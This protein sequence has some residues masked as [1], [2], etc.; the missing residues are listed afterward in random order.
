[1]QST[2]F[3]FIRPYSSELASLG[4]L[5]EA[6]SNS[7]PASA[8]VKLRS[9]AEQS[10]AQIYQQ[11]RL[12]R[13]L[14]TNLYDLITYDPFTSVIPSE[15]LSKFHSL[16][17]QGNKA[18]H[19]DKGSTETAK[20]I[21]REAHALACWMY[22]TLYN[23]DSTNCPAFKDPVSSADA[24]KESD[25]KRRDTLR[26]L[27]A[28]EAQMQQLLA[29]LEKTQTKAEVAEKSLEELQSLL[30]KGRSVA[31]AL[32]FDEA[33]TRRQM[34]DVELIDAGWN[35]G[36]NRVSTDEVGQ[37]IALKTDNK[38]EYADYVLYGEDG[39]PLAVVEAKRTMISPESGRKQAELY[40]NALELKH[41]QRPIIFYT[42]GFE[43]YLWN[44]GIKDTPRMIYGFYS[45]DSLEYLIFQ[46]NNRKKLNEVAPDSEIAGRMYQIEAVKR[47]AERF[48]NGH[49]KALIVQATGTG[50]TRVAISLCDLLSRALWAKRILFLCDRREL[51]KQANNVF[52]EYLPGEPRIYVTA[53]TA[54]DRDQRIYLATYPAM[55]NCFQSFDVGFFD[56]IIADESHRSIYNRYGDL[57]RYF[58]ALQVGLTATPVKF[59][60]KNTYELFGCRDQD[61][62]FYYSYEEA[63]NHVP[64]YLVP[65]EVFKNTTEFMRRGIKYS[66]MKPE[67]RRQLEEDET[68]PTLIDYEAA[69]IDRVVFN[70]DTNRV[71]LRNLMENGIRE[72]TGTHPGK[73]IIF[74]RNHNHAIL[75]QKLFDEMFPQYG[76]Q[77]CRVIDNYDPRAEQLI[78]DFKGFGGTN[79]PTIAISVDMLDTGIDI[80]EIVNLVF[81]KPIKSYV[82][83]WQMIG[84]GTRLRNDLFGFGKDKTAFRIFDH[85]GNFEFFE[86]RYKESQGSQQKALLQRLFE[87]RLKLAETSLEISD[88]TSF[89]IAIELIG[90]DI[91]ALPNN[92]LPVKEKWREVHTVNQAE[93]LQAFSPSTRTMLR[94][95]IAPLMQWRNTDGV[96]AA[97]EFDLIVVKLEIAKLKGSATFNDHRHTLLEVLSLLPVNANQVRSKWELIEKVRSATFWENFSIANLEHVRV[98]LRGLIKLIEVSSGPG[99]VPR[100]LDISEDKD[101]IAYERHIP[102]L[103]GLQ[104][105]AY[106][107]R[108]EELLLE[109]IDE[110]AVLQKIK[111]GSPVSADEL[112]Q[113]TALVLA[114]DAGVNLKD[115]KIHFPDLADNLDIAIRSII[116][117]DSHVVNSRFEDFVRR[118]PEL[119]SK[120][121]RFLSLLQHHIARF[122]T[123]EIER[124]YEPP[125]TTVDI[126]GIDGVFQSDEQINEILTIIGS[127]KPSTSIDS[128]LS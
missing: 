55:M 66:Q 47:V 21:L 38:V 20:W 84:R 14:E 24:Q 124:L 126:Q 48:T 56:L 46:R 108:V 6:Y 120:Q 19:G 25:E 39:K 50:K 57:F 109:L 16:R 71:V 33:T 89:D 125:F 53:D 93:T 26:K 12:S 7:D 70:K 8:L 5:A 86:E 98:E 29:E 4:G 45:K 58:D 36:T 95:D 76:G 91:A 75:L 62:T 61:P 17:I 121:I 97:L 37:E 35:V 18:A 114:Q 80:P 43:I 15:V 42:N 77:F 41:G 102:K 23:G 88:K 90:Q 118:H 13:P 123:I 74:A 116:G 10:V 96:K 87:E 101:K 22:E 9:F 59:V 78:D 127:F 54:Q 105:A 79:G 3:E 2:N 73:S 83:F 65:F 11:Y 68:D 104:L 64:P 28:Q 119:T 63:I 44:D 103:E 72:E 49:R 34:I 40:A 31:N 100:V 111:A 112:E 60:N 32:N 82:K 99:I 69:E 30:N 117:M 115:L 67:L 51:R 92:S 94:G 128:S 1:M 107:R 110:N 106:R 113:L 81:A 85:W 52:K 122:G 27:A